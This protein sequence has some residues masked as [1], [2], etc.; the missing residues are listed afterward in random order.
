MASI[1]PDT[2]LP[3]GTNVI[4]KRYVGT[5]VDAKMVAA[6]PCG[7][8]AL[9]TIKFTGERVFVRDRE[10]PAGKYV[11][12]PVKPRARSVNYSFIEVL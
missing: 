5:V 7:M 1:S 10:F 8:I 6:I 11:T 9:H 12:K 3:I 4:V 2:L